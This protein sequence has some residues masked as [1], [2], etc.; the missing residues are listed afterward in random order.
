VDV[1]PGMTESASSR[2]GHLRRFDP[3]LDAWVDSGRLPDSEA[4]LVLLASEATRHHAPLR[5]ALAGG[6]SAL[7]AAIALHSAVRAAAQ[8]GRYP[9]GPTALV[10]GAAERAA[11]LNVEVDGVPVAASLGAGR[12]RGD[13]RV[14]AVG[15]T[16]IFEFD[17]SQ[18]LIFVSPRAQWPALAVPLGVAVLD[19]RA[20]GAAYDAARQWALRWARLIHVVAEL[21]PSM[22]PSSYEVDWPLIAVEPG[23][24]GRSTSWPINGGIRLEVTGADPAGLVPARERIA[25]AA[26]SA[27]SWPAPLSVAASLSRALATVAVPLSLYDTHTVGTIA[28]PFAE[29]VDQLADTRPSDLPTEWSTFADTDWAMLKRGLLDA[30]ADVEE[31]NRKAEQIG[32]T[33]EELLDEGRDVDIWVDSAI[34]GR[35]LQTHLLSAGFGIRA[36]DFEDSRVTV[37]TLAEAHITPPRGR[38]GI[39]TGLPTTWQLP[40]IAAAGV[41]GPLVVVV[42]PFEA[43][44]AGRYFGWMLNANRQVRQGERNAVLDRVLGSGLSSGPVPALVHVAVTRR[45]AGAEMTTQV[46]EYGSDVAEFAALADDDW[47]S[48]AVQAREQ[49]GTDASTARPA[50][51]YLVEPGPAVLLLGEHAAV[52]RVVAG[53]LRPIPVARLEAGMRVLGS[54]ASGGVFAAI[55]PHLDQVH[56]IGTRFWLDQWDD[57]LRVAVSV[58]GGATA[59]AERLVATGA[60]ISAQAVTGWAS[61][62][63][64]G[65]RDPANVRRV[66]DIGTHLVVAHHHTRVYAVM[67]GVRIEHGQIGR[68]LAV[69]LRRHVDGDTG[70]FDQIE[71]RLGIDIEA[72]LGDPA[73]YTVLHRL[74]AGTAP[75]SALGRAHSIAAAQ[76]LFHPQEDR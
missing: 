61:P 48:L 22:S 76:K 30:V 5:I 8:P 55:R 28:L 51:A 12:L 21:D 20:L 2:L 40:A 66:A 39:L 52:D 11:A 16:R 7:A 63:R 67:R 64:I 32:I 74:A 70:A 54:K 47:L 49:T 73:I 69:A 29:R 34:H 71:E 13:G 23:R 46:P 14:Q 19:R 56:G 72:V 65:P 9:P 4:D 31:R 53:R 75:A 62:Y 25:R 41:G 15:G 36:E 35:A 33:V 60:T 37:R 17:G 58:T 59:L 10:A 44:R 1:V 18:R 43:D 27:E 3:L 26:R 50:I 57:A 38:A 42:Y 24:W 68:Q 6:S 45:D